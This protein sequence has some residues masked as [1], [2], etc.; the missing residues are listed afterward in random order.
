MKEYFEIKRYCGLYKI[1]KDAE[2]IRVEGNLK[3]TPSLS[4]SGYLFL[5]LCK[6]GYRRTETLHRLIAETFIPNS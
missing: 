6:D 2:V 1:S 5:K 3:L 4:S